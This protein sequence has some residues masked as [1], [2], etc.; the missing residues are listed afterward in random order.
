MSDSLVNVLTAL[1]AGALGGGLVALSIRVQATIDINDWF[2]ERRKLKKQKH[3]ETTTAKCRKLCPH[4]E[5]TYDNEEVDK[6]AVQGH[7]KKWVVSR[8]YEAPGGWFCSLCMLNRQLIPDDK[9]QYYANS[10]EVL[11]KEL[12][13]YEQ[14][15]QKQGKA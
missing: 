2:K 5:F 7:T 15:L 3:K 1:V 6:L 9:R 4:H 11:E 10:P 12:E 13:K 8:W 14:E